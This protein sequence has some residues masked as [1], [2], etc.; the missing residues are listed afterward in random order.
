MI[1]CPLIVGH[2]IQI[3]RKFTKTQIICDLYFCLAKYRKIIY[4]SII[5]ASKF[6]FTV[7]KDWRKRVVFEDKNTLYKLFPSVVHYISGKRDGQCVVKVYINDEDQGVQDYVRQNIPETFIAEFV[8]S[9]EKSNK[10]KERE[11]S[12]RLN[13]DTTAIT[14]VTDKLMKMYSII[15][16]IISGYVK[17]EESQNAEPCIVLLCWDETLIPF[18]EQ[19]LPK[20]IH[21]LPVVIREN[22]FFYARCSK[23]NCEKISSGCYIGRPS[24]PVRGSVGFLVL[25][26]SSSPS[27]G[28]LTA[29]HVAMDESFLQRH[30]ATILSTLPDKNNVYEIVHPSWDVNACNNIIGRVANAFFGNYGPNRIGIDAAWIKLYKQDSKG[31]I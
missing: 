9:G 16:G 17:L 19:E 28:F 13:E 11:S 27:K 29:A 7:A 21:G 12:F 6:P 10:G 2:G 26:N 24:V 5:N 23:H 20:K 30:P 25:D 15:T 1:G 3:L 4:I 31:N 8:R 14:K 18:G 22:S